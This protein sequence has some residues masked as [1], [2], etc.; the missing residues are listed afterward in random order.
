MAEHKNFEPTLL[1]KGVKGDFCVS[2]N[3]ERVLVRRRERDFYV[4]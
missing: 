4:P 1:L 3:G 2:P